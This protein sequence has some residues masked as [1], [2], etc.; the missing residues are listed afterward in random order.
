MQNIKNFSPYQPSPKQLE[1]YDNPSGDIPQF[2]ISEDGRDWHECQRDFA[3]NTIKIMYDADGV[4]RSII[5]NPVPQR[6]NILAVSMFFPLNMSVA[7]VESLPEGCRDD[8][9][10]LY[11]DGAIIRNTAARITAMEVLKQRRIRQ[12]SQLMIPLNAAM[13]LG[14]ITEAET[15]R[16]KDLLAYVRELQALDVSVS[17]DTPI[18]DLPQ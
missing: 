17:P 7:E 5:D 15:Q 14:D 10:W 4:I 3:D 6:G 12:A 16:L 11:Q 9:T 18:P 8:G 2:L 13:Q 1:A